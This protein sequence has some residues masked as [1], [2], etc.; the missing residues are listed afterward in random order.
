MAHP[1]HAAPAADPLLFGGGPG[2]KFDDHGNYFNEDLLLARA[3]GSKAKG[4]APLEDRSGGPGQG[5]RG[6]DKL[7]DSAGDFFNTA[8]LVMLIFFHAR[9]VPHSGSHSLFFRWSF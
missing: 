9:E 7:R 2:G 8:R 4:L 6:G 1:L 3:Q 5:A